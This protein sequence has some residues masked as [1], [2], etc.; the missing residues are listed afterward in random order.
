MCLHRGCTNTE[1][2][3]KLSTID[4]DWLYFKITLKSSIP[5]WEKYPSFRSN[6]IVI[7][8]GYSCTYILSFNHG[9]FNCDGKILSRYYF[10][11]NVTY[12]SKALKKSQRDPS[13]LFTSISSTR[14]SRELFQ[15]LIFV[16]LYFSFPSSYCQLRCYISIHSVFLSFLNNRYLSTSA[17]FISNI[18][19]KINLENNEISLEYFCLGFLNTLL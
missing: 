2:I 15:T 12:K 4:W 8:Y 7:K 1:K 11:R 10:S 18:F 17:S 16:C 3:L 9:H 5:S 19:Y 6:K 13:R 14:T